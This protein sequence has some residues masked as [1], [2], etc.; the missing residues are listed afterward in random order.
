M[1]RIKELRLSKGLKQSEL[2]NKLKIAQNT[3]S[4]W[5][6]GKYEPDIA[7]LNEIADIF[8]VSV[9]YLIGNSPD[10]TPPGEKE[11]APATLEDAERAFIKLLEEHYGTKIENI[12]L[13]PEEREKWRNAVIALTKGFSK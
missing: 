7:A 12:D 1:N 11:K 9:D 4:T 6:I 2:A 10:P 8:S 13:P 3:L 5:E